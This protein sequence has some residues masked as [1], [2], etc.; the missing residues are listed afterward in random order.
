MNFK[1]LQTY[2][3]PLLLTLCLLLPFTQ[4]QRLVRCISS[5]S[6]VDSESQNVFMADAGTRLRCCP[7]SPCFIAPH[8]P[9]GSPIHRDANGIPYLLVSE[10][11]LFA[12]QVNS[13][14]CS[15][16]RRP[17]GLDLFAVQVV[18]HWRHQA[19]P[20]PPAAL[21][22]NRPPDS[23]LPHLAPLSAMATCSTLSFSA[24]R[25]ISLVST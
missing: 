4:L 20:P 23:P 12:Q 22:T 24:P 5:I 10:L 16:R 21:I 7:C 17:R 1:P 9:A 6:Q 13:H 14:D 15:R 3:L 2:N 25:V 11:W 18:A 8:P 19:S